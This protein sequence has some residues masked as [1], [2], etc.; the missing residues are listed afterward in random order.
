MS[1]F[2]FS[3]HID[4]FTTF[5]NSNFNSPIDDNV[6]YIKNGLIDVNFL[7][8]D[9]HNGILKSINAVMVSNAS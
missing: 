6:M 2:F 9:Q 8:L 4:G 1:T 5:W 3:W 7:K